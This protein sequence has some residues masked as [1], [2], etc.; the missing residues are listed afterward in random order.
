M[1]VALSLAVY[2]GVVQ[3]VCHFMSVAIHYRLA[4]NVAFAHCCFV[5]LVLWSSTAAGVTAV[6]AAS[7]VVFVFV[8]GI[9]VGFKDG[10]EVGGS[11]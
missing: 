11:Y 6:V 8:L 10:L 4:V 3:V 7:V 1:A 5:I 2:P 9:H